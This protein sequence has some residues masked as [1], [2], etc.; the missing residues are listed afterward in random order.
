M[1][2]IDV[3]SSM[4]S[5]CTGGKMTHLEW[6]LQFVKLKVQ[7]MVCDTRSLFLQQL[8]LFL[9]I[10]N[11]RKTDQCG[12]ILFGSEGIASVRHLHFPQL[13]SLLETK[14]IIN[15]ENGGYENVLEYIP[16]AQANAS[17]LAKIDALQPSA[18]SGDRRV[19]LI[20]LHAF[21]VISLFSYRCTYRWYWHA[22]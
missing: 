5:I 1:F 21:G 18:T 11:G 8:R 7:E 19:S 6:A 20:C 17:T 16:I 22:S 13:K 12:I 2:L 15:A 9:Q 3:S 10:F 4:G 14:N